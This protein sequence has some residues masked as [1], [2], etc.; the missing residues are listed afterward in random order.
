[1]AAS[2]QRTLTCPVCRRRFAP[3]DASRAHAPFCSARCR[4]VDL[5]KW[6]GGAYAL[7]AAP[8]DLE[9]DA[10]PDLDRDVEEE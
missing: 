10:A 3:D 2:T 7:P 4:T 5:G 9:G 6:L 1:V 8:A